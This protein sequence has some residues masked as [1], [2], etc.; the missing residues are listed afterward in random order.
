MAEQTELMVSLTT[1]SVMETMELGEAFGSL[2]SPGHTL[3]L[4]GDLGAGKTHFT[5]GV[6][7]GLGIPPEVVTSPTFV[8]MKEY[9]G[10]MTHVD[11]YRIGD[12]EELFYTGFSDHLEGNRV[13]VVEWA[14]KVGQEW[15]PSGCIRMNIRTMGPDERSFEITATGDFHCQLLESALGSFRALHSDTAGEDINE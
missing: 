9:H 12:M 14:E 4:T 10:L 13:V 3:L 5:K 7:K 15:F 8:V 11:L 6:A 1:N 2:S